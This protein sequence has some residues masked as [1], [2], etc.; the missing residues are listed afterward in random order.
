MKARATYKHTIFACCFA[1]FFQATGSVFPILMLTLRGLYGLSYTQY[2]ILVSINFLTQ[3]SFDVLFSKPVDRYGFRRFAVWAPVVSGLGILLFAASP[4]LFPGREF[5]GFCIGIFVFGGAAGLQELLL[6]P[7]L[8][9]L[10]L[11]ADQKAKKMSLLHSFFAWGQIF[12]VLLTTLLLAWLGGGAWQGILLIWAVFPLVGAALFS[13]VP[14][15][16]RVAAGS[17]MTL[18]QLFQSRV[19]RL[20]LVAIVLGGS[21]EVTMSQ[22]ASA[23]I[24]QGLALPKLVGDTLGVCGFALM[25]AL[26]RTAYGIWGD[27]ISVHRVMVLGS[28][29]AAVLYV[30]AALVPVPALGLVACGLTGLCVS[31]L[32]P[33]SVIVAARH[34]P[35]A[36]ASMFALLSASG[37]T[38]ASVSSLLV[39]TVTDGVIASGAGFLG[40]TG[41]QAGIRA[42][43]L[44]A[45][46]FPLLSTVVN[47][48]LKKAAELEPPPA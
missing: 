10:P 31:I 4:L 26:G 2:G 33:G 48:R 17:E 19:F 45:A 25:L 40:A 13:V 3:I 30:A 28:A 41:E 23:F 16:P 6:S 11:P 44:I 20:A 5:V 37:D 9:A 32:W 43:L 39:G 36:G 29:G 34:L 24:E 46:V 35:L 18:R 47:L 21:A 8:D 15:P 22:W 38:G 12:A 42:G 14:L 27:R 7:I 1:N